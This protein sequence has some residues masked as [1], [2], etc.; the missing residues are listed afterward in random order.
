MGGKLRLLDW[1][2]RRI[3]CGKPCQRCKAVCHY[4][5]IE[6]SGEIRY[7]AC[8]Q[9]LDCVGVYHDDKRCVPVMLYERK[10]KMLVP[11]GNSA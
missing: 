6:A 4:D 2:T 9:C 1:L 3:E 5:A 10:G 7:G 11:R 8:F